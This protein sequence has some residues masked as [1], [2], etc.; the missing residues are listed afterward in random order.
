M[1]GEREVE[2]LF[3]GLPGEI[4]DVVARE[5]KD[6]VEEMY[7]WTIAERLAGGPQTGRGT[8]LRIASLPVAG[9]HDHRIGGT[10]RLAKALRRDVIVGPDEV[11]GRMYIEGDEKLRMIARTLFKGATIVPRVA[12]ALTIPISP[13]SYGKTAADF[14]TATGALH[15]P[16]RVVAGLFIYR[17]K[18]GFA[19]LARPTG[20]A[21]GLK[22]L[23]LLL[24]KV[25]IPPRPVLDDAAKEHFPRIL[26]R[27][28][29]ALHVL[30]QQRRR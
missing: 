10:G 6:G 8:A 23:F 5:L 22:L 13:E 1:H 4:R 21:R 27:L 2:L 28:A 29:R 20:V 12:G 7:R 14:T 3:A 15:V 30:V 9:D 17:S 18:R 16:G 11:A 24:K 25:V 19:F 26:N